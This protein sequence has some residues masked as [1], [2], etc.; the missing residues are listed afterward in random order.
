MKNYLLTASVILV[1]A[2]A[3]N[4][5]LA[6]PEADDLIK[7]ARSGVDEEVLTAYIDAAPGTFDLSAD[8]IITLNDLG[9][10]AQVI[11]QALRHGH[12]NEA[13][14]TSIAIAGKTNQAASSDT[15][16]TV[17]TSAA[18]APP[19][20]D[21]NISFFYESLYPYGNWLDIDGQ[22]CW[23]PNAMVVS[24]DWAPY[25]R[26]GH[27]VDS[28]WG[29]CWVS[30]Y[31]WGWAPFHY[32][33]WF[34]HH[35]HGW[36]WVPDTE[37]GPAW[38]SWRR[39][40]DY[41]GWAPLPPHTRYV[42]SE[43]FYFGPSRVGPDF[44][45]NLTFNDYFFVP[46][47][48]FC[49]QHPWVHMVPSVRREDVFRR[50]DF[51]RD[52][53]GLDHDHVYNRGV[54]IEDVSRATHRRITP[55]TIV[56]DDLKPGEQIHRGTIRDNRF[57]IYKPR[58]APDAPKNPDIIRSDFEQRQRNTQGRRNDVEKNLENRQ[59]NAARQTV[60]DQRL[61]ADN[62]KQEEYHLERAAHYEADSKKQT[63]F[64]AEAEIQS[65]QAKQAR[66]HVDN[67]NRRKSYS[68]R[69]P[70]VMPQ[71]RIVPPPTPENQQQ[72]KNQVRNQ[73]DREA[74]VERQRDQVAKEM[75][76]KSPPARSSNESGRSQ[77]NERGR[78]ARREK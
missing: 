76:R 50:T 28:D 14:S 57:S 30:D 6:S 36:C 29:W 64:Q 21:L 52:A 66:D 71:S 19:P 61:K 3:Y 67:I 26:H 37:W 63:E 53:Y 60:K 20:G 62:A 25:C 69:K 77:G 75:V 56:D 72:V 54:P 73:I 74:R 16:T 15:G 23:Q 78:N 32:G 51:V 68:E 44:E 8:D 34:R 12:A 5:A 41:Y 10:P 65:M 1:I 17:L 27:W 47:D 48:H 39:G 59:K 55:I 35:R 2:I 9:V 13:D 49:D 18:V 46:R 4:A 33:R 43:G 70:A 11:S 40:D 42:H 31:S 22:W 24:P 45:F 58:I 7:M 38:V